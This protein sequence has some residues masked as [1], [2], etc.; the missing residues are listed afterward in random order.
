MMSPFSGK[1]IAIPVSGVGLDG[2]E[3]G[4]GVLE[5]VGEVATVEMEEVAVV[6]EDVAA[7]GRVVDSLLVFSYHP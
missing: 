3:D 4:P 6:I 7:M 1:M 2:G 5:A